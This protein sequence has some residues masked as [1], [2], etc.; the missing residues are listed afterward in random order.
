[1]FSVAQS[2]YNGVTV[3]LSSA[4]TAA[5]VAEGDTLAS[6]EAFA[7]AVGY[8]DARFPGTAYSFAVFYAP[9]LGPPPT[10]LH[11]QDDDRFECEPQT[12]MIRPLRDADNALITGVVFRTCPR[13]CV[14]V[15]RMCASAS[16][17]LPMP[18][19]Y[20]HRD[21]ACRSSCR[22]AAARR[23][24]DVGNSHRYRPRYAHSFGTLHC[25]SGRVC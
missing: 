23:R 7:S 18:C 24:R 11:L 1:M 21:T 10:L 9:S 2:V 5:A 15:L 22:A 8:L 6:K 4:T 17:A 3:T 16:H 13:L 25:A 14:F 19:D 20:S 12:C